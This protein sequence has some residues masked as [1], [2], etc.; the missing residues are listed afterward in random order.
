MTDIKSRSKTKWLI[1]A[2]WIVMIAVSFTFRDRLSGGISSSSS[3][4]DTSTQAGKGQKLYEDRFNITS[5]S[6]TQ[7][8]IIELN[9]GSNIQSPQWRNFT[10]YLTLYLNQ[11]YFSR[12]YTRIISEPLALAGNYTDLANSMVSKDH[13]DGLIFMTGL[14]NNLDYK[15]DVPDIRNQMKDITS[16]PSSFYNYVTANYTHNANY[17]ALLLP[18]ADQINSIHIILTG[19]LA[20]FTDIIAVAKQAFDSSE[21]I[22]VV[23]V[24]IIL[25]F[26]FRSPLGLVIPLIS[27]V[28][29]LFP[30]YLATWILSQF[31][32]VQIN[33]FLPAIIAMIGI[34]V[35][36]DYNLFN[37]TRFKEE[38]HK[39]K[40]QGL[41]D[42]KWTDDDIRHAELES[43]A[44]MN[45]SSGTAVMYSGFSVKW[46][47]SCGF[48]FNY[49]LS[50]HCPNFNASNF[51]SFWSL[52]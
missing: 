1:I 21:I 50:Y 18:S 2:F 41:L 15:K 42:G 45:K 32:I 27:M 17:T 9:N 36:I 38:F 5:N 8:L 44:A 30:T 22:A 39:R 12:N 19:S 16:D 24:L 46:Y 52:S 33:D 20:N 47:G 11:T 51:R 48:N 26:V 31:G 43:S 49:F 34:A 29:A 23:V 10:L 14:Q 3:L 28:A 4:T 35:A 37:L 40:A 25:A 13:L 7:I 6:A